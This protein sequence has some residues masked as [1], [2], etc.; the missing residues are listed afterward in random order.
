VISEVNIWRAATLMLK[1]YGENAELESARRGDELAADV[2]SM[3]R[4]SGAGSCMP[5]HRAREY[6]AERPDQLVV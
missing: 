3:A 1:R 5:S 4:R 2:I 6:H